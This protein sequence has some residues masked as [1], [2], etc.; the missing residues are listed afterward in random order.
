MSRDENISQK[1]ANKEWKLKFQ[2]SPVELLSGATDGNRAAGVRFELNDL[3]E[4]KQ[5][6]QMGQ[7][8]LGFLF[9][10]G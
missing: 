1:T 7:D 6:S 3:V 9:F 5:K 2:R 10:L 4:V 8:I